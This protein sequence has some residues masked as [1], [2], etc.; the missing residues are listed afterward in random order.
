MGKLQEKKFKTNKN[1]IIL[2][3]SDSIVVK[4]NKM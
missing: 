3:F 4:I 1:S 2:L